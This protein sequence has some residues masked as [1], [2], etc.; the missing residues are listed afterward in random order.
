MKKL[1]MILSFVSLVVLIGAPVLYYLGRI[2]LD[3]NK[4]IMNTA[5]A[6]WFATAIFW[7][8]RERKEA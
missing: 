3:L 4:Q 6:V 8:G 7:M 2:D 5:T 1:L